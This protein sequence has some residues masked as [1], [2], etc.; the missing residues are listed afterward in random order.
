MKIA[1]T[2]DATRIWDNPFESQIRL[3]H[4]QYTS[5]GLVEVYC[6]GQWGTIC[7]VVLGGSDVICKQLGYTGAAWISHSNM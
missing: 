6:N 1:L 7:G 2:T 3:S 5:G 4:G